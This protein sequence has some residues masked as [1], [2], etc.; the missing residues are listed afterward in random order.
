MGHPV[1]C[2]LV[3]E[4]VHLLVDD[5]DPAGAAP[6][7]R[8]ALVVERAARLQRRH[9]R[10]Q[11]DRRRLRRRLRRTLSRPHEATG[12]KF[13]RKRFGLSFS[14]KNHLSFG[15]RFPTLRQSS[16]MGSL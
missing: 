7:P 12:W 8:L 14:L 5:L 1:P 15:L 4:N 2:Y 6:A 11:R 13:N 10:R 9:R 16:E 3:A